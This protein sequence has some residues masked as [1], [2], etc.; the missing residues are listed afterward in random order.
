[1]LSSYTAVVIKVKNTYA[2]FIKELSGAHSQGESVEE[3]KENLKEAVKM[4]VESN[5]LHKIEGYKDIVE[6]EILVNL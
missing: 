5:Y 2:G 6:E 1:M 4:V 3:V